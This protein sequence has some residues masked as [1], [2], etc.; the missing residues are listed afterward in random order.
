MGV[1]PGGGA[2]AFPDVCQEIGGEL[3][4]GFRGLVQMTDTEGAT[5]TPLR[6]NRSGTRRDRGDAPHSHCHARG[7]SLGSSSIARTAVASR[8]AT[9]SRVAVGRSRR[10]V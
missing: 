10:A 7:R 4:S 3:I 2:A 6:G 1:A 8:P 9:V 5:T